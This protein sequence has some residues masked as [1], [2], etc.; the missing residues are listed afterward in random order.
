MRIRRL[1]SW[2]I[3]LAQAAELQR[4]LAKQ[5]VRTTPA[6]FGP[7][8]V[9]GM[10]LSPPDVHGVARGAVVLLAYPSLEVVEVVTAEDRPG[11]PYVPGFLAFREAPVLVKALEA[12]RQTPDLLLVD[13]QGLAHPRRFGLACH[14]G[15]LCDIPTIGC[16]KSLLTGRHPPLALERGAWLPLMDVGEVV[17]AAV[18][19]RESVN[20]IYVSIGHRVDLE[21]AVHWALACSSRY[22][23]PEPTRLAHLAAAGNLRHNGGKGPWQQHADHGRLP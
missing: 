14:V 8:L 6:G 22:R 1:H 19:T 12:L 10:D 5:V 23:I 11:F 4:R 21:T 2:D 15:L 7:S 9:A 13:G 20:P 18:R 3:S 17:G 16:A